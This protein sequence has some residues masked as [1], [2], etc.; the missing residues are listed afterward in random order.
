MRARSDPAE[1]DTLGAVVRK[2]TDDFTHLH[3]SGTCLSILGVPSTVR[4]TLDRLVHQRPV[5]T[6]ILLPNTC[7]VNSFS[8]C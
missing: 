5:I 4:H 2:A 7:N 1:V 6:N 8:I 3:T